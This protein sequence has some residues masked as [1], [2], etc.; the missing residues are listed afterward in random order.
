VRFSGKV[1]R[2]EGHLIVRQVGLEVVVYDRSS[3]RA[4][5]LGPLAAAV[6][7]ASRAATSV[8]EVAERV[9]RASGEAI[10]E[11][12]V[13]VALRRLRRAGLL[14][15]GESR[16]DSDPAWGRDSWAARGIERRRALRR[17][18]GLTGLAVLTLV[19]PAP[20]QVAATCI[21]NGDSCTSSSQCCSGCCN[22]NNHKCTG[23]GPCLSAA[24]AARP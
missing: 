21:V 12:A 9:S 17:V 8:E 15:G 1:S 5:C 11:G 24:P 22:A 7:R 10:D 14:A 3:H 19:T 23:G 16:G 6:W 2:V 13:R 4:H 20:A 18:A